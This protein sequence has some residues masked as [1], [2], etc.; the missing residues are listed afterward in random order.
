MVQ[1]GNIKELSSSFNSFFGT[2]ANIQALISIIIVDFCFLV[3]VRDSI[4]N[5]KQRVRLTRRYMYEYGMNI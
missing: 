4:Q 2:C 3:D 1:S 5:V